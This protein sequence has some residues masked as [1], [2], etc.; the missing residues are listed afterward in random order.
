MGGGSSDGTLTIYGQSGSSG[1]LNIDNE[2]TGI[3]AYNDLIINGGII[4]VS[5]NN[6]YAIDCR[7]NVVING[8]RVTATAPGWAISGVNGVVINGGKVTA[9][10]QN[11]AIDGKTIAINGG[12]VIAD[13]PVDNY[14]TIAEQMIDC[15][16]SGTN[17]RVITESIDGDVATAMQTLFGNNASVDASFKRTFNGGVASTICLPFPMTSIPSGKVYEFVGVEYDDTD[18]WVATMSDATPSGNSVDETVANKP[19]LFMPSTNGAV[20]F[21]GTINPASITA[22]TTSS[23]DTYWTFLG[24][25]SQLTYGSG[26]FTDP[27][28]GFAAS[29]AG[30]GVNDVKAG[31]FVRADDGA[32]IPAFRAF[33]KYA[34]DETSLQARATRGGGAG[35]P[36]TITVRLLGKNGEIQGIGEIRLSTGEVTFDSNAWYDLNGRRLAE[37]PTQKGI[38]INGGHKVAIK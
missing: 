8:G 10:A 6:G 12:T 9:T 20:P 7:G 32:F 34:G 31:E 35:I 22:G 14:A 27:V 17:K 33:L 11:A 16:I 2:S 28:F 19:Y 38:Y 29:D 25:Y 13:G 4:S 23:T 30:Q 5:T 21:T 1:A 26:Q 37:K 3:L 15:T 18:G 24:T 36:E